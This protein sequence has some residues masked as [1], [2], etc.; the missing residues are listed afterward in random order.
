MRGK[1]K[2]TYLPIDLIEKIKERAE[3]ERRSFNS[4]LVIALEKAFG[5]TSK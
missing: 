5:D 3:K 1:Q 4:A 2:S